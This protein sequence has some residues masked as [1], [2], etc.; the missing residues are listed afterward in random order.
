[1]ELGLDIQTLRRRS[2]RRERVRFYRPGQ[3]ARVCQGGSLD[4]WCSGP[5]C[6]ARV[7]YVNAKQR[8]HQSGAAKSSSAGRTRTGGLTHPS[9]ARRAAPLQW[10]PAGSRAARR[11]KAAPSWHR[12]NRKTELSAGSIPKESVRRPSR[13]GGGCFPQLLRTGSLEMCTEPVPASP[14]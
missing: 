12:G 1:M 5:G 3:P 13:T 2:R 11:A 7:V 14:H 10:I 9:I 6:C 8:I 4:E